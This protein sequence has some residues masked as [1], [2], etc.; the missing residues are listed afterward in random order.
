MLNTVTST[1]EKCC[2]SA[3]TEILSDKCCSHDITVDGINNVGLITAGHASALPPNTIAKLLKEKVHLPS[4]SPVQH[5][6][7]G[8]KIVQAYF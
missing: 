8:G 3:A 6:K 1:E 5:Y 4:I 7:N 2:T